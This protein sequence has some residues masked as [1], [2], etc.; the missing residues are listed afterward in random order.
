MQQAFLLCGQIS[1]YPDLK[2]EGERV[3]HCWQH[4]SIRD[5]IQ[6]GETVLAPQAS[7]LHSQSECAVSCGAVLLRE[8]QDYA[9]FLEWQ[10]RLGTTQ[11]DLPSPT[12]LFSLSVRAAFAPGG[13]CRLALFVR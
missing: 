4:R 3:V 9:R 7:M 12:F 11:C 13:F 2:I 10:Q 8:L 1:N 5:E 6:E